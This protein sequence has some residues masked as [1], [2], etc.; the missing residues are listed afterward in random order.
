M[1]GEGSANRSGD[2]PEYIRD[3]YDLFIP[4]A[5]LLH[6][7]PEGTTE[8][9]SDAARSPSPQVDYN[10]SGLMVSP[11]YLSRVPFTYGESPS[12]MVSPLHLW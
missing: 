4:E 1:E 5:N 6:P 8:L 11:L 12:L 2:S 9:L 7:H 3:K 10:T